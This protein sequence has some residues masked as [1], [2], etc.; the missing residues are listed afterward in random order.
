MEILNLAIPMAWKELGQN[1]KDC[2]QQVKA[3]LIATA[4]SWSI[5]FRY[6][7]TNQSKVN[8]IATGAKAL[9]H[10]KNVALLG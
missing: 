6:T 8:L 10:S 1:V 7:G 4:K 2:E 5:G 9:D 3:Y